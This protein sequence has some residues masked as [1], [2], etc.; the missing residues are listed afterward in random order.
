MCP[1]TPETPELPL[2]SVVGKDP[3]ITVQRSTVVRVG[4]V[5]LVLAA[6]GVGTAIGLSIGSKSSPQSNK[7]AA[8]GGSTS[9]ANVSTTTAPLTT[10]SVT[11]LPVVLS[12]G[13]GSTPR[14]RPTKITVG[15]ATGAITVTGITWS[16]WGAPA[17]GQGTGT[18]NVDMMSVPAIVV[19][20]HAVN[21]VFQDVSITPSK[22]VPTTPT[23]PTTRASKTAPTT[24][25]ATTTTTG[26]PS[27]VA[28]TQPGSGWGAD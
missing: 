5:A 10:T 11:S 7:S 16:A 9:T 23:I 3:V 22:A 8:I 27:P 12:C 25:L 6:L 1:R 2:D 19:V 14:T 28:A 18:L 4:I 26:G 13:P 17:G 20:F 21:G 15:C 24:G